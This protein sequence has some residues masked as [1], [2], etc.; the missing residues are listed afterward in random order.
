MVAAFLHALEQIVHMQRFGYKLYRLQRLF[1]NFFFIP[2]FEFEVV[3]DAE[4]T[5][6]VVAAAAKNRINGITRIDHFPFPFFRH[7]V[8]IK[9]RHFGT[10]SHHLFRQLVVKFKHVMNQIFL[11]VVNHAALAAGVNHDSD[12]L[13]GHPFVPAFLTDTQHLQ[14]RVGRNR[15]KPHQRGKHLS[16]RINR[17][18][19]RQ[20]DLFRILHCDSFGH[21]LT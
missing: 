7:V 13:F 15:Q 8:G 10:V 18:R 5:D 1:Q 3:L 2:V 6:H 17:P 21:Q 9:K 11:N 20:T 14:H 16:H 19:H 12:F 4:R